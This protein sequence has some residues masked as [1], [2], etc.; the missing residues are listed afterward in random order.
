MSNAAKLVQQTAQMVEHYYKPGY[1]ILSFMY[2]LYCDPAWSEEAFTKWEDSGYEYEGYLDPY[3]NMP[4][5]A[6][7]LITVEVPKTRNSD[8]RAIP[9]AALAEQMW[10][11]LKPEL[12]FDN[13]AKPL[14][15]ADPAKVPTYFS[16]RP[17]L[18]TLTMIYL[19]GSMPDE[20]VLRAALDDPKY[21]VKGS[22]VPLFDALSRI[23]EQ[24][25][26]P[27]SNA[28]SLNVIKDALIV[29]FTVTPFVW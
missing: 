14:G 22:S 15:R 18:S 2:G 6:R 9:T 19:A 28:A 21:F 1:P 4:H 16:G 17:V 27:S 12:T 8:G 23:Y 24:R 10:T 11:Y 29:D 25:G 13:P 26:L 7:Q 5:G 20:K 3:P